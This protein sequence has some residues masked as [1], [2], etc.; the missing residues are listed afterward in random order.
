MEKSEKRYKQL[1]AEERATIM[2]MKRDGCGLREM[3][4]FLKDLPVRFHA[5]RI[6]TWVLNLTMLHH[7]QVNKPI[8]CAAVRV[9]Y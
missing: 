8:L 7:G 1:G 3:G 4:R 5:S 9:R 6:G 2:L